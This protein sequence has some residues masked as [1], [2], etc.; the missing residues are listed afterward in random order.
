MHRDELEPPDLPVPDC[1]MTASMS[2]ATIVDR[3]S[4]LVF[5]LDAKRRTTVMP[6]PRTR[7]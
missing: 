7:V 3:R 2:G 4:V 5:V 1:H 6:I